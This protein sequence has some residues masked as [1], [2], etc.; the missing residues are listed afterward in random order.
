MVV[1]SRDANDVVLVADELLMRQQ[2]DINLFVITECHLV[3]MSHPEEG[4][5]MVIKFRRKIMR[6]LLNI[7]KVTL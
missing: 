5:M 2:A 1:S 4:V 7:K 3:D 6:R